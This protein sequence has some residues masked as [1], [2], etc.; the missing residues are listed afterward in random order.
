[1][2]NE[3]EKQKMNSVSKKVN[4]KKWTLRDGEKAYNKRDQTWTSTFYISFQM[5]IKT[6]L[7]KWILSSWKCLMVKSSKCNNSNDLLI[8]QLGYLAIFAESFNLC[9]LI[10]KS[11]NDNNKQKYHQI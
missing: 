7:I 6:D 8:L 1:M 10:L 4:V 2:W 11:N 3:H 5:P 9:H